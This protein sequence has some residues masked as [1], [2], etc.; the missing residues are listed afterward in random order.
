M[1]D[2]VVDTHI[3][4]AKLS[5]LYPLNIPKEIMHGLGWDNTDE[6]GI[7]FPVKITPLPTKNAFLVE[8]PDTK[9]VSELRYLYAIGELKKKGLKRT[10]PKKIF[11][12]DYAVSRA[13]RMRKISKEFEQNK[14]FVK[15]FNRL[16][17][18]NKEIDDA[19]VK[20]NQRFA[21]RFSERDKL[22]VQ[23]GELMEKQWD[24]EG[25]RK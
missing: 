16:E 25:I 7:R 19:T 1:K 17:K 2:L 11:T 5:R 21:K 22:I 20:F 4:K 24:N 23:L 14:E 6:V 10:Y 3:Y 18:T 8:N 15:V 13:S 12:K 9:P